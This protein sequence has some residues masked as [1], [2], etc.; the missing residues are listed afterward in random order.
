[1][2]SYA[3]L[4]SV[5]TTSR[6]NSTNNHKNN[7]VG[8]RH[9]LFYMA[10]FVLGAVTSIIVALASGASPQSLVKVSISVGVILFIFA[11]LGAAMKYRSK[12]Q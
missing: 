2:D 1:M 6:T 4:N 12:S 7:K 10:V 3:S 9:I 5:S 11:I 8:L